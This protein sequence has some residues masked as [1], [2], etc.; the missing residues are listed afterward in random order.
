MGQSTSADEVDVGDLIKDYTL[1]SK[2]EQGTLLRHRTSKEGFL[3]KEVSFMDQ[4]E[5][6]KA[7]DKYRARRAR[8]AKE[9]LLNL[10]E[11]QG[12]VKANFC[13]GT[14]KL[15]LIYEYPSITLQ[16]E[17]AARARETRFFEEQDLW[18][19]MQSCLNGL[20]ELGEPVQLEPHKIFIMNDGLVKIVDPDA[21]SDGSRFV[22]SQGVYYAPERF[23]NFHR[24]DRGNSSEKETI[25][26]LGMS[27]LHAA[28]LEEVFECYG[29]EE[30]KFNNKKLQE[31]LGKL[32]GMYSE[33]FV[34]VLVNLLELNPNRRASMLELQDVINKFWS[35]EEED[36]EQANAEN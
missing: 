11:V 4:D 28:T 22:L 1:E 9:N 36:E 23:E 8:P 6:Q 16:E 33:E 10:V 27:L 31:R 35:K 2:C 19:I 20:S 32:E 29:Y 14:Y 13:S 5:Y 15:Y 30:H 3:L 26:G 7:L 18:S 12:R 21:I 34:F 25:F 24:T 17:I